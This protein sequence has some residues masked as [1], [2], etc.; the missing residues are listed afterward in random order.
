LGGISIK[1]SLKNYLHY[2]G[3]NNL[4]SMCRDQIGGVVLLSER[5][6]GNNTRGKGSGNEEMINRTE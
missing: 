6:H 1:I 4:G 5:K 3:K 2:L